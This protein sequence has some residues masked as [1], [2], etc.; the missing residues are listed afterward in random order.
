MTAP[1]HAS[2]N[3]SANAS[4]TGSAS[5]PAS[6]SGAAGTDRVATPLR[7]VTA[8]LGIPRSRLIAAVAAASATLL[9]ALALAAVSAWLITTAWTMPPVLDLTVAVVC[10]RALGI[11]RGVFRWVDRM[12]T[13]DAALRGVVTLR[14]RL[15]TALADRPGDA[16]SRL[17]R[18]DLLARLGD[19]A[20]ELAD[21][22]IRA[23][24]PALVAVVL[25][26][27]TVL[28]IAPISPLAALA[29]IAA[30]VIAS[31]LG[32]LAAYRAARLTEEAVV[33][34]RGAV[35]STA[36]QV[37][38]D[39]TSLRLDGR[40]DGALAEHE[41]AQ[42][43]YD[44]A[45]DRAALPSA[46]AAA[47]V[48]VAMI[49]ALTGS[50]LAAGPLWVAGQ[51]SAGQIG[52]L[53]L[54]PLSAFE[55]ASA[56]PAAASQLARSQAAA[57]RLVETVGPERPG[58]ERPGARRPGARR[59]GPEHLGAE[60]PD[61]ERRAPGTSAS[62]PAQPVASSP[63][64]MVRGLVA[65]WSPERPLTAP[66]DL[67]LAPGARV[68][69][70]GAS[71][72]GKSTLVSTLAGLLAPLAG[73]I[74]LDGAD[75]QELPE[76]AVR[77]AMV[78]FAEDAHVFATTVR[79]NLRVARGDA[80]DEEI[81]AAL[82]ATG[83]ADWVAHLP[84]GLSHLLGPDGTTVS[85]GE[86]RRLLLARALVRRAPITLLDE[87]TEHLDPE[88]ARALLHAL[89][90]TGG[91]ALLDPD[92]IVVVVTHDVASL[93]AGTTVLALPVIAP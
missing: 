7:R 25:G 29:M 3:T 14:T 1:V 15:F 45:L 83:L 75:L 46:L 93:P 5:A 62:A 84:G 10:V 91:D 57:R 6:G 41:R 28:L 12:A 22:V 33:A 65:G 66:L 56:L 40:L 39:A 88:R 21:H 26:I 70:T 92:G 87:P 38:D 79:E 53:L 73:S 74:R 77:E 86:R 64:L 48:P 20:Q 35:T 67:D 78:L 58:H 36:L 16:L 51:A 80:S 19:D 2:A 71:G 42:R 76:A 52:V 27:C 81:L 9:S 50:V 8:M 44:A 11:S 90:S 31:A 60:H 23:T 43:A 13:H 47:V 59:P 49:L 4:G 34:G 85:G 54:L 72:A 30:L 17:R 82:T 68:A 69:I 55:A 89:L 61:A 18:G 63:S 32:P 37:L 24:V